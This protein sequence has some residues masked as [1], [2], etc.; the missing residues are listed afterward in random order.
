MSPVRRYGDL[1]LSRRLLAEARPYW[2]HIACIFLLGM[3]A[4]PIALLLPLPLQIV[5]FPPL[6]PWIDMPPV[7]PSMNSL[8]ALPP[9]IVSPAPPAIVSLPPLPPWIVSAG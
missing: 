1:A 6:P 5:S 9:V 4:T 7:V 3:L 8:P 2:P